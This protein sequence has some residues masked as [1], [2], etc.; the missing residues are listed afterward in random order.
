MLG[1]LFKSL[2]QVP[3]IIHKHAKRFQCM[4]SLDH[5]SRS[6]FKN[7]GGKHLAQLTYTIN[8]NFKMLL[9]RWGSISAMISFTLECVRFFKF[10]VPIPGL[11]DINPG[12]SL[13]ELML[14]LKLQY[15]GQSMQRTDSLEKTLLLG[16]NECKRR[17][18]QQRR[19]WLDS[20]TDS[21]DMNLSQL[22][23]TVEDRRAWRAIVHGVAVSDMTLSVHH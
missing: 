19:R 23:E 11:K 4:W 1:L 10:G 22:Q 13:E 14:K 3:L 15:F 5:I 7:E 6:S 16:K 9:T 2:G 20:I 21:M 8:W 17:R 12:Y 18:G